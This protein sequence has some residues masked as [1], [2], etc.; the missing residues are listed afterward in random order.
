MLFCVT[1]VRI[2]VKS[3][4]KSVGTGVPDGPQKTH[5]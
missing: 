4:R 3:S 2:N 1:T 5:N